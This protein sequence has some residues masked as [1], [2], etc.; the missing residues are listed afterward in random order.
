MLYQFYELHRAALLPVR[1]GAEAGQF[2][3]RNPFNPFTYTAYGRVVAAACEFV[4]QTTRRRDKPG[5]GLEATRID[6]REVAVR[7]RIV[8]RA[9][10]GQLKHFMRETER[11]DP[12]LLIVAPLS[13]HFATL[14]RGTV[15][16]LLPDHEIYITDWRDARMVPLAAGSFDLDDYID[17]VIDYLRLL[18]PGTQVMAVCQPSVPVLA[19]V[20]LMAADGDPATPPSMVLM[21]GP[22]DARESPTQVNDLATR[23]PLE[24]FEGTVITRVPLRYPGFLRRVYPGFVQLS[25]FMTLNLER[26][27]DAHVRH[28]EHLVVGDGES[29]EAHRR[30]YDEYTAV[31]DLP[32]EYY[33]QTIATVFQEFAL[34]RGTMTSRGRPIELAAITGTRLMTVEGELDDI[35]GS[36]QTRAA[37]RLCAAIPDSHKVHYEQKGVGHYGIFNGRRWRTQIAPRVRAFLRQGAG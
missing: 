15:K 6:G 26:H 8:H 33:L 34:A 31:M 22:V 4:E 28:F 17:L 18:G 23:R 5:F 24:W 35:S 13:G 2:L 32:A 7:E 30:F 36:G 20:A 16:T 37:H 10:F 14:L 29:A 9:P 11:D 25:G 12:R 21:G 1:L 27:V 19:A 3:F